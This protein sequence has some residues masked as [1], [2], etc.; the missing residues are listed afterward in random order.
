MPGSMPAP[1]PAAPAGAYGQVPGP[2]HPFEGQVSNKGYMTTFLL[3]FFLGFFGVD[4]FYTGQIGLGILK[5]ITF[6]GLGIWA[7]IDTILILSG[8]RKDKWGRELYGREKDFKL[9][10]IIF[11]IFVV[12][13]VVAAVIDSVFAKPTP[14]TSTS[15]NTS[16]NHNQGAPAATAQPIGYTYTLT[17]QSGNKMGVTLTKF[18]PKAQPATSIDQ[19]TAGSHL[20]AAQFQI[21]NNSSSKISESADTSAVLEDQQN[22]SYDTDFSQASDCQPFAST[23]LDNLGPGESATGCVV[24]KVPDTVTPIKVKYTPSSGFASDSGLWSLQ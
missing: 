9:S 21:T 13:G 1:A 16:T 11:I 3:S 8:T 12:L 5:L 2:A 10:I 15:L 22:Q 7:F 4:R 20:A 23:A 19:P 17:D 18:I 6:G 14:V 24:Y